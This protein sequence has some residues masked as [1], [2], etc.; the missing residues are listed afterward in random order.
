MSTTTDLATGIIILLCVSLVLNLA[1]EQVEDYNNITISDGNNFVY[2]YLNKTSGTLGEFDASELPESE[3]SVSPEDG[4]VFTD[5]F[6]TIKNW[7]L[8]TTGGKILINTL[9]API[10]ILNAIGLPWEVVALIGSVW[11]GVFI[12]SFKPLYLY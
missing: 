12:F 2:T 5:I 1:R 7:A 10:V 6:K 3:E 9:G 8:G 4:S 11:Y